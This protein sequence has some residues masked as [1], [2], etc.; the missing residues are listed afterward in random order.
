MFGIESKLSLLS[1]NRRFCHIMTGKRK[2]HS[3]AFKSKVVLEALKERE[4]LQELATRYEVSQFTICK[5]KKE[6]MVNASMVFGGKSPKVESMT[7]KKEDA[8]YA[9]IG[10]LEMEV[11]FLKRASEQLGI[12]LPEDKPTPN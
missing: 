1:L 12:P 3:A 4:T 8:L 11:D 5:W 10:R 2:K 7:E 9:K 6:F